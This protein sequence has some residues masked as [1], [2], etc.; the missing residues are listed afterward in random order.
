MQ[1]EIFRRIKRI[2]HLIRI[3]GTGNPPQLA[4]KLGISERSIYEYLNL[5]KDLGAPIKYCH[6]RESYYYDEE[7]SFTICF[8]QRHKT[9]FNA[10]TFACLVL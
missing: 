3:K 1:K 7:G 6:V 2:D 9:A 4:S 8:L 5:M 10:L